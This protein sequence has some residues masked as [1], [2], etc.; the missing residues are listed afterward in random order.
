MNLLM[1]ETQVKSIATTIHMQLSKKQDVDLPDVLDALSKGLFSVDF[2]Q[3]K[4]L[5]K[6]G[7]E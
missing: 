6:S 4:V 7:K 5:M 3:A 2:E 1:N